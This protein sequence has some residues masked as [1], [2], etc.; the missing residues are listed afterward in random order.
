MMRTR[1]RRTVEA[2]SMGQEAVCVA[3]FDGQV[4]EGRAL[5]ESSEL[6]FRGEFRLTLP[7]RDLRTVA[8]EDD[9]LILT[10]TAGTVI[11]ELGPLAEKWAAK[12]RNPK[13]LLDKLGVKPGTRVCLLERNRW[14]G[15]FLG[16]LAERAVTEATVDRAAA[17]LFPVGE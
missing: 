10:G 14:D 1:G 16:D 11:L 3:R 4:A 7:F 15:G 12:I 5:L 17:V 8:V 9:T 6:R 2:W 13:G